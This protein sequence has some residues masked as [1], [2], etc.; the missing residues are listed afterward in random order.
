MSKQTK[1]K[2]SQG[3]TK[4]P[5]LPICMNCVHFRKEVVDKTYAGFSGDYHWSGDKKMRCSLGDFATQKTAS[6][7]RYAERPT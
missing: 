7:G 1:A 4:K 6:C 5:T 2:S 3:W